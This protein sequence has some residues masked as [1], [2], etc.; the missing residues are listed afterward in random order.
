MEAKVKDI[1][2]THGL[3]FKIEKIPLMGVDSNGNQIIT[4]YFG[5]FNDKTKTV[6]NTCKAGYS[7]SQ[8]EDIVE[9]VLKGTDKFGNKLKITKG[10]SINEGRRVYL[11]LAIDGKGKVG[12][13]VLTQ[14][15][16]IIDSNDGSTSLS[17]GISDTVMHC[18]N[19]FFKFY[20]AGDA[21]FRHTA[22]LEQKIASIPQLIETA[23]G[24][25]LEQIKV[26]NKFLSTPLTKALAKKMI[27]HVTKFDLA[28]D[29]TSRQQ[30]IH[31]NLTNAI[32]IE[33]DICG[34]NFWG[35]FNGITRFTTHHQAV[36]KRLNGREE[37]LI[38]GTAY[39]KASLA[40]DLLLE[41]V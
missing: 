28:V 6:I 26:Y 21:K 16:T 33:T 2:K 30:V 13:D 36:P 27:E 15:V 9:M 19:Q 31:D 1:L 5:L 18:Q 3:D 7:V 22:T 17:I 41:N 37:S 25:S 29:L 14:Y 23:L 35:A 11:Q 40:F 39:Q 4:P 8:N 38:N 20:K 34:N 10:G 32:K 24:K 12:D